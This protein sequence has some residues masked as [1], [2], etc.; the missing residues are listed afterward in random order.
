MQR[1]QMERSEWMKDRRSSKFA[2]GMTE[3]IT[4]AERTK[5][6]VRNDYYIPCPCKDCTNTVSIGIDLVELHLYKRGFM[7][8]YTI[9]TKHGE[10]PVMDEGNNLCVGEV[11]NPDQSRMSDEFNPGAQTS[12]YRQKTGIPKNPKKTRV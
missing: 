12:S 7:G 11:P 2:S 4:L 6:R 10:E 1:V 3:F 8:G 9:W 5:K